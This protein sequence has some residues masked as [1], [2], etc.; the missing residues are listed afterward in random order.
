MLSDSIWVLFMY[1]RQGKG[2]KGGGMGRRA[3]PRGI[4]GG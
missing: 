3:S 1:M 4:R 2:G